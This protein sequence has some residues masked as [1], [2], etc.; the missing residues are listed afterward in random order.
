[1]R[2]KGGFVEASFFTY[3][4]TSLQNSIIFFTQRESIRQYSSFFRP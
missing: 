3:S 4:D 2:E 1:M